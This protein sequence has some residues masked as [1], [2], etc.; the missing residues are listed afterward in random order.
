MSRKSVSCLTFVCVLLICSYLFADAGKAFRE[1]R[2]TELTEDPTTPVTRVPVN[3]GDENQSIDGPP[4]PIN[5]VEPKLVQNKSRVFM[6]DKNWK[7]TEFNG[8][9]HIYVQLDQ[10]ILLDK[11][12]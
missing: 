10:S 12:V 8:R 5:L 7:P 11:E 1:L 3:F 9:Q 4:G 2:K 6:P